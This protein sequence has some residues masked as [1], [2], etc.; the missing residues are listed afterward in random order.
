MAWKNGAAFFEW[1]VGHMS[2][3]CC[4]RLPHFS[5]SQI[6]HQRQKITPALQTWRMSASIMTLVIET[7]LRFDSE[8]QC[9]R[10]DIG[11]LTHPTPFSMADA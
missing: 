8:A 9:R 3:L 2:Y 1:S 6:G 11:T 5:L 7:P 4:L 10:S